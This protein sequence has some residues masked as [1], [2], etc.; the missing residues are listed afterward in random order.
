M[1]THLVLL[2]LLL[3]GMAP[4]CAPSPT[5][6]PAPAPAVVDAAA[7]SEVA[8]RRILS[9]TIRDHLDYLASDEMRGRD[10]PSPE[11][12]DAADYLVARFQELGVEPA[13]E[14][15]G[16]IQRW[17]FE[18]LS[19]N[20]A[21]SRALMEVDGDRREWRYAE[22]YFAIPS[23]PGQVE[24]VPVY[25]P[26]PATA[27]QGLPAEV[28]GAPLVVGLPEGLGPD[29]GL[30]IQ[31]GMQ[32]GAAGVVLLMDEETDASATFQLA[33]ALEG[34]IAGEMPFPIIGLRHDVG[35]ELLTSA[36]LEAGP[37]EVRVME[38]LVVSFQSTF[39]PEVHEVPNVVGMVR[40][41]DPELADEYIVLTAHFDHVGVGPSDERGDS[42]YSGADDNAS[43]TAA[44]LE[45]AGAMASLPEAPARSVLFLA[46]SG[47]E[48]GLLGSAWFAQNPT[49]PAEGMVA[50]LNMDMVSRNAP[51]TVHAIGEEYSTIGRLAHEVARDHPELGLVVA[52]DPEPEEQAFLRSDH[53]SFV[54][55]GIPALMLTTWLHDDYHLPSDTPD[56]ADEDKAARIARL[57]FLMA[58]RM[59]D[60]PDPPTWTAEGEALLEQ[61]AGQG[62]PPGQP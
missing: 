26:D 1:R 14:E 3:F 10:T 9:E 49:I 22:E 41:S 27:A 12:E 33:A 62:P 28:A 24:G 53:F 19:L 6:G 5:P 17:P 36:G 38:N 56:R 35:Q 51:D 57:A 58:H 7:L 55:Q 18:V 40:G 34:G 42:I 43:G 13:G 25:A 60:T 46:V 29:F 45:V 21:E 50:A 39:E 31:A 15:G 23:L 2:S 44:L 47:E 61:L 20:R 37:G 30:A 4:A 48:K 16:F 11:L 8:E 32:A 59:A 54:E 52:P